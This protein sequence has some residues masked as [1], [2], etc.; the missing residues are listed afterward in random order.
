MK[1]LSF[2]VI[3]LASMGCASG[4]DI[5]QKDGKVLR[6]TN[7]KRDGGVV[8]ARLMSQGE[9]QETAM[10]AV[11]TIDRIVFPEDPLFRE[12]VEHANLGDALAV[13]NKTSQ[14]RSTAREWADINGNTMADILRL[15]IPS[16]IAAGKKSELSRL[17]E[18][19]VPTKEADLETTVGLLK[20]HERADQQDK[21]EME[22][23]RVV[24][25]APGTLS[26]A[27]AWTYMGRKALDSRQ[28]NS[29]VRAFTSIR[30]FSQNWRVLQP[31][32]LLGAIEGC[33]GN[34]SPAQAAIFASD[35]ESEYPGSAQASIARSLPPLSSVSSEIKN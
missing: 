12:A 1:S 29:A 22:C 30:L 25:G 35:L 34:A 16:L 17:L 8:F 9:N 32:A 26:A 5:Y 14:A 6:A 15:M 18:S 7:L 10:V 20:L 28:W 33:R 21:F 2:L 3:I 11:N 27:V 24:E 4:Q 13:L 31:V 23:R 19:W